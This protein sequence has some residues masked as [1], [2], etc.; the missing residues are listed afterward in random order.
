MYQHE[1]FGRLRDGL[2]NIYCDKDNV[3][4]LV[5]DSGL[6]L[7]RIDFSGSA[8]TFW[9]NIL[10]EAE[11]Q[12]QVELIIETS[13]KQYPTNSVLKNLLSDYKRWVAGGRLK[14]YDD[15]T[16]TTVLKIDISMA[17]LPSTNPNLFGRQDVLDKLSN[18]WDN[19][20]INIICLVA[21]GGVGKTALINSWL[22]QAAEAKYRGAEGIY[23]WSFYTHGTTEDQ[24]VSADPFIADALKWFG[25]T[26]PTKGSPW[27]K[28]ERLA[29]LI[30][31]RRV[32]LI[33]DGL[34]PLQALSTSEFGKIKDPALSILLRELARKN[35]GLVIITTRLPV[36]DLKDYARTVIEI[37]LENLSNA[38][39]VEYLR[40]LGVKGTNEELIS[41]VEEFKGHALALT[42]LGSYLKV[43]YNGDIGKREKIDKILDEKRQGSHAKRVLYSYEQ[44]LKITPSLEMLQILSLFDRPAEKDAVNLFRNTPVISDLTQRIQGLPE[45]E[46]QYL[47]DDLRRMR[48]IFAPDLNNPETIDCHPLIREYF[49]E[50]VRTT[51]PAAWQE[52][53][54]RLYGYFSAKAKQ[55]PENIEEMIPLYTAA[56]H[57]CKAGR[58][59]EVWENVYKSR[60]QR[61]EQ[62]FNWHK[63][64]AFSADL[65]VLSGFFAQQ[66]SH[67]VEGLN[68]KDR[69][70][71]LNEAGFDLRALGRLLEATTSLQGSLDGATNKKDWP[72]AAK[73]ASNIS[74]LYLILGEIQQSLRFAEKCRELADKCGFPANKPVNYATYASVLHQLGRLN[75]AEEW[76]N[77]AEKIQREIVPPTPILYSVRGFEFCD[78]L[79]T[80]EKYNEVLDRGEKIKS[81]YSRFS[82]ASLLDQAL[83]NLSLGCAH[84][85]KA[86]KQPNGDYSEAKIYLDMAIDGLRRAGQQDHLPRG[87]LKRAELRIIMGSFDKAKDDLETA[88]S[89]ANRSHMRLFEADCHIGHSALYIATGEKDKAK[90][91]LFI[92]KKMIA[93][94]GYYRRDG[95]V[96]SLELNV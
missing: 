90:E 27:E 38:D 36:D 2:A 76:F 26:D 15:A 21:W 11:H 96:K 46:W 43:V 89:I 5:Y 50:S 62:H 56:L 14:T 53:H 68:E 45:L 4:I 52:A 32:L 83:N 63:L 22:T 3:K 1:V 23:C 47:I 17:R 10:N 28:G 55:Y 58:Y 80:Q 59:Q 67:P 7:R 8:N 86:Q 75:E 51:N 87:F 34:E 24:Q 41:A 29:E 77:K 54:S 64:G 70:I 33:L 69:A 78:L 37:D 71:V 93:D 49:G 88:Y 60:I 66:W 91:S 92:A 25:D 16:S 84:M 9:F 65:E 95:I 81:L 31:K 19:P 61:G 57:G 20:N 40:F 94:I 79:L 6:D 44:W 73:V 72:T 42:L 18:S 13:I 48:L 82:G 39:G 85:M 30:R 74:Q 12:N 35:P